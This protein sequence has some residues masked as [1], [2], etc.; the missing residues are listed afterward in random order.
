MLYVKSLSIS[1]FKSFRQASLLFSKGF[2]C[3]IGPNGSGKS[4]ICDALLFGLG[5]TSLH[6]LRVDK[7]ESLINTTS[8][9]KEG[10]LQKAH[11]RLELDGDEKL[12][13]QRIARSDG[14]SAFRV[15]GKHMSRQ[16]VIEILRKHKINAN[17]TNTITQGEISRMLELNPKERRELIEIAA[18]IKE[19]EDKKSEALKELDK[20]NA[21]IGEAQIMLNERIGFLK[22]LEKEKEAAEKFINLSK[23]L[24]LLNYS[25][26]YARSVELG[27]SL[28]EYSNAL[29]A[30]NAEKQNI[31]DEIANYS[32][33][34]DELGAEASKLTKDLSE[35]SVSVSAINKR[36]EVINNELSTIEVQI[37]TLQSEASNHAEAEKKAKSDI[38]AAEAKIASNKKE[39]ERLESEMAPIEKMI[40]ESKDLV[41]SGQDGLLAR[42]AELYKAIEKMEASIKSITSELAT[43]Q[44]ALQ[45]ELS[46]KE[47]YKEDLSELEKQYEASVAK[48]SESEAKVAEMEK[49]R[50]QAAASVKSLEKEVEELQLKIRNSEQALIELKEQ[51]AIYYQKESGIAEKLK[52]KFS[53][54]DGF[55]GKASQLC[56]YDD[57][58][59]LAVEAAAG[60]RIDYLVVDS[61]KTADKIIAYMK[62]E[63]LGRATFIPLEDLKV[64]QEESDSKMQKAIS[65]VKFESKFEKALR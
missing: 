37:S 61:I 46:R 34:I 51:R 28:E 11:V 20:V 10:L 25:I 16:E 43:K 58:Y 29:S 40:N 33:K 18:G 26:L 45:G 63:K 48:I 55:Y 57:Q 15:N 31:Q 2:T 44:T 54:K 9:A 50:A 59:S 39:I 14:K 6:R 64:A 1:K 35:S 22:E 38:I 30:A 62:S 32:A 12:E 47:S 27:K 7:L 42:S 21:K 49:R 24:K 60:S 65:L 19:F 13:I 17:E 8:S 5:E 4:N 41:Q 56:S 3:I 23:R 52:A 53:E 36:L